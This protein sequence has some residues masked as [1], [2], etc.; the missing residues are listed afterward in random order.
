MTRGGCSCAPLTRDEVRKSLANPLPP[1]PFPTHTLRERRVGECAERH[2]RAGVAPPGA[3]RFLL[4][5]RAARE[6]AVAAH[7][8]RARVLGAHSVGGDRVRGGTVRGRRAH[9]APHSAAAD[10]VQVRSRWR[11][12]NS[13]CSYI[14]GSASAKEQLHISSNG[15]EWRGLDGSSDG[16]GCKSHASSCSSPDHRHDGWWRRCAG[17]RSGH[18]HHTWTG[19]G[20]CRGQK[21]LICIARASAVVVL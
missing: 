18:G 8:P 21:G 16:R 6:R 3:A 14:G 12:H 7:A 9:L 2:I 10:G 1:A 15:L 17:S 19:R 5:L 4:V 20:N 13:G 11:Q